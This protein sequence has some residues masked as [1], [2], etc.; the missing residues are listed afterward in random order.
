EAANLHLG[1]ADEVGAL[2]A[3][4]GAAQSAAGAW[5]DRVQRG[6][7][8][9]FVQIVCPTPRAL[10]VSDSD[11]DGARAGP[12]WHGRLKRLGGLD[13]Y[14]CCLLS[15]EENRGRRHARARAGHEVAAEDVDGVG[16]L[17]EA[18]R[19]ID[20]LHARG[21][22]NVGKEALTGSGAGG[23]DDKDIGNA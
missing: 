10:H 11:T 13:H 7:D 6:L 5:R 15:A 3:D 16:A 12:S 20:R 19:G 2:D 14:I 22:V 9:I 1:Y 23:R 4:L 21:A 8:R 17:R 18:V